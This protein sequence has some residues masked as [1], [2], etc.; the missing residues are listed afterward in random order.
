VIAAETDEEAARLFT[1]LQQVF[2]AL[3]RGGS[4]QLQPPV[5]SMEGRWTDLEALSIRKALRCAVVGSR[6]TVKQGLQRILDETGADELIIAG[7]IYDH[8]AR[9]RS[10]EIAASLREELRPASVRR[11]A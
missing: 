8:A 10:F 2:L 6:A 1:S 11:A 5:E 7:Q 3:R 9:L 4:L